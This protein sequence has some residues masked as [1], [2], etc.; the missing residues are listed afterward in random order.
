MVNT[1]GGEF[2][3]E[4][5]ILRT[6]DRI[7]SEGRP[8]QLVAFDDPSLSVFDVLTVG[9]DHFYLT[10]SEYESDIYVMDLEY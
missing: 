10:I 5:T 8:T 9:A 3:V 1:E 2:R 6:W 7:P 4:D